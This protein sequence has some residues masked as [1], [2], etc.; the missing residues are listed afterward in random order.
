MQ[1]CIMFLVFLPPARF[2]HAMFWRIIWQRRAVNYHLHD[3][4]ALVCGAWHSQCG[5][6]GACVI[7][8]CI[9]NM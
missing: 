6:Y 1:V 2:S 3:G 4:R 9:Q 5:M 7:Y 8:G